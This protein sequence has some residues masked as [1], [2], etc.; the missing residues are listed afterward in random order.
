MLGL[1]KPVRRWEKKIKTCKYFFSFYKL[2]FC[3]GQNIAKQMQ[4]Q[5]QLFERLNGYWIR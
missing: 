5:L 3:L 4:E 1:A 2:S